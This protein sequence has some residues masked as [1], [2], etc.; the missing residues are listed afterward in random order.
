MRDPE[1]SV[2]NIDIKTE[3]IPIDMK[4]EFLRKFSYDETLMVIK[5]DSFKVF[6]DKIDKLLAKRRITER[7]LNKYLS[8][9]GI[10]IVQIIKAFQCPYFN[11][12]SSTAR[13]GERYLDIKK[14]YFYLMLYT[15]LDYD[16]KVDLVVE[17]SYLYTLNRANARVSSISQD[18]DVDEKE[19]SCSIVL[20][21]IS[22]IIG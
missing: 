6:T 8:Q 10:K 17:L 14:V 19:I 15:K 1:K 11:D 22:Y 20:E 3:N 5:Y 18:K 4:Y 12:E 21:L 2:R 9:S 7:K 13:E 16:N